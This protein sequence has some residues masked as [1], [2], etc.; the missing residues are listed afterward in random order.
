MVGGD[1]PCDCALLTRGGADTGSPAAIL[2]FGRSPERKSLMPSPAIEYARQNHPRFLDELKASAAH[3]VDLHVARA[4]RRLPFCGRGAGRRSGEKSAW[5]MCGSS[6][7]PGIRW[8]MPTGCMRRASRRC[9]CMGTTTC[10]RPIRWTSGFRRPLSRP[11]AME[12]SMR[13][14]QWTTR[15]RWWHR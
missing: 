5:R 7:R 11:S 13:A 4:Q 3:S 12:I 8:C 15:A 6:R 10:S 14:G 9:W 1:R 2:S